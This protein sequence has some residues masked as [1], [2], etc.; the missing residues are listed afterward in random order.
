MRKDP[1][2]MDELSSNVIY[3]IYLGLPKRIE[4]SKETV[5]LLIQ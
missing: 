1:D 5:L 4:Y 3:P 2:H